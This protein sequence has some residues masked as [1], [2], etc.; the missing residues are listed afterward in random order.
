MTSKA[1]RELTRI[2]PQA[3]AL[4]LE[5]REGQQA[6]ATAFNELRAS[7]DAQMEA[8][9]VLRVRVG[10]LQMWIDEDRRDRARLAE[11]ATLRAQ[12]RDERDARRDH[13]WR[14]EFAMLEERIYRLEPHGWRLWWRR[15]RETWV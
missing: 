5:T 7:H 8:D 12:L 4:I 13:D 15:W 2:G 6:L 1:R 9:G 11:A 3:A 10:A 14:Y